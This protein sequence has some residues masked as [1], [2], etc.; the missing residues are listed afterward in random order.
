M[1]A[2]DFVA[3][4]ATLL[5]AGLFLTG[6]LSIWHIYLLTAINASASALQAPAFGAAVTQLVPKSQFGRANGLIHLGEGIGL[7]I[8]PLLAGLFIGL[9]GLASVLLFD[10]VT[11]IIAVS[12]L[13]FVRFPDIVEPEEH[14]LEKQNNWKNQLGQAVN[15][16]W[17]RPGLF[18]LILVFTLAN[19]FLGAAEAVLTPMVLSFTSADKLGLIMT[20]GG[21]GM[22]IGS[23]LVTAFGHIQWKRPVQAGW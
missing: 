6:S 16:L 17:T 1:I 10:M 3:G 8:A 11:F 9:F 21:L 2:T 4:T 18:G 12:I 7:V 13:F 23:L 22:L 14:I 5:T 20:M 15:Y 19:F